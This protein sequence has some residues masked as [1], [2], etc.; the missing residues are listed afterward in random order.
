M[1]VLL[2]IGQPSRTLRTS[3][4]AS[5]L[6]STHDST[7]HSGNPERLSNEK[8]QILA[9]KLLTRVPGGGNAL[10]RRKYLEV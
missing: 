4:E 5:N 9:T 7:N 1:L 8:E 6:V 2:I 3:R 10:R